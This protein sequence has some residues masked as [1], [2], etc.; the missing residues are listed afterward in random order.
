VISN[1]QSFIELLIKIANE[2]SSTHWRHFK[3]KIFKFHGFLIYLFDRLHS[4]YEILNLIRNMKSL[5]KFLSVHGEFDVTSQD[6]MKAN[7]GIIFSSQ[8]HFFEGVP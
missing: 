6:P 3:W 4:I 7:R 8:R 5:V 1:E 2:M